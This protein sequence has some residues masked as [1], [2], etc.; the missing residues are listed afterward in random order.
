MYFSTCRWVSYHGLLWHHVSANLCRQ[1]LLESLHWNLLQKFH[2]NKLIMYYISSHSLN[3]NVKVWCEA[4]TRAVN[5]GDRPLESHACNL[6]NFCD[7]SNIPPWVYLSLNGRI[8]KAVSERIYAFLWEKS[9][10]GSLSVYI[11]NLLY[12]DALILSY[13]GPM[14]QVSDQRKYSRWMLSMGK[15]DSCFSQTLIWNKFALD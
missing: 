4:C 9:H 10:F 3:S 5:E 15:V 6:L 12:K 2:F 11:S 13:F 7:S 14:S 1:R 8:S